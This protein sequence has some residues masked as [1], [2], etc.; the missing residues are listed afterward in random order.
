MEIISTTMTQLKA[1]GILPTTKNVGQEIGRAKSTV[2]KIM[3]GRLNFKSYKIQTGQNLT[4][5][6][7]I[8]RTDFEERFLGKF[9]SDQHSW[10]TSFIR[11]SAYVRW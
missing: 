7:Q 6:H 10:I 8:K 3:R 1:Q 11:T 5:Q 2:W 9:E 4:R